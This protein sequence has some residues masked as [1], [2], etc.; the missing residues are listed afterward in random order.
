MDYDPL[1]LGFYI[2]V[3]LIAVA[4]MLMVFKVAMRNLPLWLFELWPHF[5]GVT[6]GGAML[7][8]GHWQVSATIVGVGIV[9]G[10]SWTSLLNR[11]CRLGRDNSKLELAHWKLIQWAQK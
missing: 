8:K 3:G 1:H 4:L 9:M 11:C 10:W 7:G 5:L 2:I 6:I